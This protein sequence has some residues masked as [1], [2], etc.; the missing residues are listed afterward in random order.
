MFFAPGG[1]ESEQRM[2]ESGDLG[3]GWAWGGGARHVIVGFKGIMFMSQWALV[4]TVRLGS[5]GGVSG[6]FP[7][8]VCSCH[9]NGRR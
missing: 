5:R 4:V 6:W 7:A 2:G 3:R 8:A 9:E 1:G